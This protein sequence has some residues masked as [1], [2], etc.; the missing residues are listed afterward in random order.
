MAP[1]L[2][3]L[4]CCSEEGLSFQ[5]SWEIEGLV[6]SRKFCKKQEYTEPPP[7]N[8]RAVIPG[9]PGVEDAETG[10]GGRADGAQCTIFTKN[11]VLESVSTVSGVGRPLL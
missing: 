7:D 3:L 8:F 1:G 2:G 9:T 10:G 6:Q 4:C 5:P 11:L